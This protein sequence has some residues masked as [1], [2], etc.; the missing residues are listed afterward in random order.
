MAE[1]QD[2]QGVHD[3]RLDQHRVPVDELQR[4]WAPWRSAYVAG[5]G[6]PIEGCAFCVL[7]ARDRDR[8]RESL[9]VH[10]G[11]HA[12]V[13][14]NA[15]PYNPGHLMAVPYQHTGEVD[16]LPEDAA[17]ELW[18]LGRRAATVLR[19]RLRAGGVN[20]GMNLGRAGGAGIAEHVHLHAVPRWGGDTNFISVLGGTR[21]LPEALLEVHDRL[22]DAFG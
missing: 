21:V 6:D 19:D 11:V 12:F 9:V 2:P 18:A 5:D 20:L 8:D 4:L 3:P 14:L 10:R 22:V 17:A 1:E 16:A 7:P 15:F 13:V